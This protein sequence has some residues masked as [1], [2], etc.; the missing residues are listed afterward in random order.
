MRPFY[1]TAGSTSAGDSFWYARR[2]LTERAGLSGTD[3]LLSFVDLAFNPNLPPAETVF[4]HLLCTNR[5][6][7]SQLP[8]NAH[9]Q[10]EEP[11]PISHIHCLFK[12]TPSGYPPLGG[13]SRW[14]LIS[15]LSLNQLSLSNDPASLEAFKKILSL[16][17][18]S[19]SPATQRQI[20]SIEKMTV[21]KVTRRRD[22]HP[23][24]SF[25]QGH[26][27]TLHFASESS[28]ESIHLFC[29]VLQE[30]LS[31]YAGINS[32]VI[33]RTNGKERLR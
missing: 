17:S 28:A 6:L 2:I 13:S 21:R 25:Q 32:F 5:N 24:K 4:A 10:T 15:N 20:D 23:W 30:L 11:G 26:E 3:V 7:A 22:T 16:Y 8:E 19:N 18:L 9:L 29:A 1:S 31:L 27:V 14:A 12:P 33:A